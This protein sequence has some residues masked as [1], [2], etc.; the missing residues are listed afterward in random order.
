MDWSKELKDTIFPYLEPYEFRISAAGVRYGSVIYLGFGEGNSR[1]HANGI[2]ITQYPVEIEIGSDNWSL[3]KNGNPMID[4][5]FVS[6]DSAR[7]KLENLL[8]GV[9]LVDTKIANKT[10]R[11]V[12]DK[13]LVLQSHIIPMPESGFLYSFQTEDGSVWETIDGK[14]FRK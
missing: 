11:M 9:K 8:V 6:I 3:D 12:L 1:R 7:L 13:G 2:L 10:A 14:T 5:H 4:S